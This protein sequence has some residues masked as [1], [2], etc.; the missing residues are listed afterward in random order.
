MLVSYYILVVTY[1]LMYVS[2]RMYFTQHFWT[3]F[4]LLHLFPDII[5]LLSVRETHLE[6]ERRLPKQ[7]VCVEP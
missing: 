2:F 7:L 6:E 5:L 4:F 1:I 3:P